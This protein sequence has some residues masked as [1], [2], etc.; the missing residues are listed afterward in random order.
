MKKLLSVALALLM[1]LGLTAIAKPVS[2]DGEI[3]LDFEGYEVV[4]AKQE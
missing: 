1:V 2:A 4:L 3:T